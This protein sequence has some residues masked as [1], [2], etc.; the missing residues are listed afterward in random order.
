MPSTR[1]GL[2]CLAAL[3]AAACAHAPP[4]AAPAGPLAW[5]DP[6]AAPQVRW[7]GTFPSPDGVRRSFW[8]RATDAILGIEEL[9][10][11]SL[12][13]RPFGLAVDGALLLVADPD[14]AQVLAVDWKKGQSRPLT[15]AAHAW[16]APMGVAV[17]PDGT[18][19]V[20]DAAGLV[21]RMPAAGGC[22][23]F[24]QE[25][26][27][28]PTGLAFLGGRIWVVDPPRHGLV[29]FTA[30]GVEALRLGGRGE[31]PGQLQFPTA[32]AAS[33]EGTLLVVDALNFRVARFAA[34]GTPLPPLSGRAAA[35]PKCVAA[36][37]GGRIWVSDDGSDQLLRFEADGRPSL[38]VARSGSAAGELLAPA[39][40][41]VAGNLLFV[42]DSLNRRV[43]IFEVLG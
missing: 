1:I 19:Y 38:S 6:P 42:A 17:S 13:T 35:R 41:A 22:T 31:G 39:G 7:V 16:A 20:A 33:P 34:D 18:R 37:P 27:T 32:V 4:A 14:G 5:P 40:L 3:A 21:A 11:A 30:D 8:R 15:C 28:R 43:A 9:P 36:E 12:L 10:A 23:T 2:T 29:A 24:G 26:L 25:A